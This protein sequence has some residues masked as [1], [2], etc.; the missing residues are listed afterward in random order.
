MDWKCVFLNFLLFIPH[1]RIFILATVETESDSAKISQL[2]EQELIDKIVE[3]IEEQ[4]RIAQKGSS[5]VETEDDTLNRAVVEDADKSSG[6]S[7]QIPQGEKKDGV[8]PEGPRDGSEN[9]SSSNK[10]TLPP[11]VPG[12]V[13]PLEQQE[14]VDS[15]RQSGLIDT[16][17]TIFIIIIAVAVSTGFLGLM[18]AGVCYY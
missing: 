6:V 7:N 9:E 13:A 16:E 10:S 17:D 3:K 18:L 2:T 14:H 1:N 4:Q 12:H 5:D 15:R 8:A 11:A